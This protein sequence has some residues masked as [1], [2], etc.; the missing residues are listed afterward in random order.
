VKHTL[1]AVG[2]RPLYP[3]E[4]DLVALLTGKGWLVRMCSGCPHIIAG[5]DEAHLHRLLGI[6]IRMT[7][8]RRGASW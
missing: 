3:A 2:S 4:A 6:H 5:P 7:A 1:A 8:G